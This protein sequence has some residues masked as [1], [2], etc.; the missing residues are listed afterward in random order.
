VI[1]TRPIPASPI[2]A[3]MASLQPFTESTKAASG[4]LRLTHHAYWYRPV[5][6]AGA[7]VGLAL[8]LIKPLASQDHPTVIWA[9]TILHGKGHVLHN[10]S[11]EIQGSKIA[12][13]DARHRRGAYDLGR[14][15]VLPGWID[16]HVH[17]TYHFGPNGRAEDRNE[18][19][20]RAA[21][22]NAWVTLM[23]GFTTVQ[24]GA[25]DWLDSTG[26]GSRYHRPGWR[27]AAGYH[28]RAARRVRNEGRP[29]LQEPGCVERAPVIGR[30][31]GERP[32]AN[33]NGDVIMDYSSVEHG[34]G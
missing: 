24:T 23:A 3:P 14:F 29:S 10:T 1:Q 34:G 11:I 27:P 2:L 16:A 28:G 17:I 7:Y 15:T 13:L 32:V 30:G 20:A 25:R 19:P 21:A 31:R 18:T 26:H 33:P 22:S 4:S 9:R 6:L 12:R 5:M 8:G